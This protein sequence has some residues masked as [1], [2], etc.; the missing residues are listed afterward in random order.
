MNISSRHGSAFTFESCIDKIKGQT[1]LMMLIYY[2][3]FACSNI[4][5]VVKPNSPAAIISSD[6][7]SSYVMTTIKDVK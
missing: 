1:H 5:E 4:T 2:V 6:I 7:C 3:N